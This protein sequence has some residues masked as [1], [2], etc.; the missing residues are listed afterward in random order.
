MK[1]TT[2]L[3]VGNWKMNPSNLLEAE[4][5]AKMLVRGRKQKTE[6]AVVIAPPFPYLFPVSKK[7]KNSTLML[8]AQNVHSQALGPFTGEVSV[9]QLKDFGVTHVIV[10][11][12]ERRASGETNEQVR[13]KIQSLLKHRL[14]PIVCVG[15]KTRDDHGDYYNF[16]ENQIRSLAEVLPANEMKK[17]I[18]AYEPIWAIG[19]GKNATADDVKEMQLFIETT[20]TKLYDR[21]TARAVRVLYGGSVTA[22][23]VVEL[24]QKSDM[25][26]FLVGGASLKPEEFLN[27]ISLIENQ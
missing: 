27:I 3:I 25:D 16:I 5:L 10:G 21:P 20:L 19:T 7:I 15:E 11:H 2:P 6:T 22:H 1:K 12:S 9:L 13:Q 23:N 24:Y 14:T 26:G 17:V 4:E 18:L 8:G